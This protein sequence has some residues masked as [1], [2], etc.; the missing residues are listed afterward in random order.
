[1]KTLPHQARF[2]QHPLAQLAIAFIAG[3]LTARWFV[4]R[5]ALS[6]SPLALFSV[7]TL[8]ALLRNRLKLAALSL[9]L[10]MFLAGTSLAVLEKT[11]STAGRVKRLI[12]DGFFSSNDP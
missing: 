12:A 7:I 5:L 8:L 10:A 4:P 3:I 11:G 2:T 6:L 1:M 9:L